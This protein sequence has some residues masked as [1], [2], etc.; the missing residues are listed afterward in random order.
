MAKPMEV[1][2]LEAAMIQS[3]CIGVRFSNDLMRG[4]LSLWYWTRGLL[5]EEDDADTDEEDGQ[6]AAAVYVFLEEG[7]GGGGVADVGERG[8]GGGGE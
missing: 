4:S 7:F 3:S 6:P 5:G 1:S 8:G 2:A